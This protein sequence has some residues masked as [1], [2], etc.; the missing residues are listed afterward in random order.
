M[1]VVEVVVEKF[2]LPLLSQFL[3]HP[4]VPEKKLVPVQG[5]LLVEV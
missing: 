3:T 5:A 1:L 4:R 2:V